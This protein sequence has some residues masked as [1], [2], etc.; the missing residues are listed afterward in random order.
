VR[1]QIGEPPEVAGL[2]I[3][4][5]EFFLARENPPHTRSPE[6]AGH[7]TTRIEL[8][9][10][11]PHAVQADAIAAGA[12]EGNAVTERTHGLVGGGAL[13]MLQGGVIDPTGHVWLIGKFLD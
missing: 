6:I 7:V 13:R 8:F 5:A 2:S 9:V 10:D 12:R 3:A 11:D 1:W 4:G